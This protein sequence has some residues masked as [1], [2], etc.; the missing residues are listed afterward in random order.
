MLLIIG[1]HYTRVYTKDIKITSNL[2][3]LFRKRKRNYFHTAAY[4]SGKWDGYINFFNKKTGIINTGLLPE[5]ITALKHW[6]V[7]Y[8]IEDNRTKLEF[9]YEQINL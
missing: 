6:N 8:E 3:I 5:L 4:K 1:N 9:L 7:D 2:W